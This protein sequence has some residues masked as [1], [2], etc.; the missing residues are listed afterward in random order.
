MKK[1]INCEICQ[2]KNLKT[3]EFGRMPIANNYSLK[4]NKY[5]YNCVIS[6]CSNCKVFRKNIK[7][8]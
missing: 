2:K 4:N 5:R 8:L 7:I 3:I 1:K 6:Y